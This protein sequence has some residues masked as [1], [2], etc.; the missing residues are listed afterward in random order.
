M[1]DLEDQSDN[2]EQSQQQQSQDKFT[3]SGLHKK[4]KLGLESSMRQVSSTQIAQAQNKKSSIMIQGSGVNLGP[5]DDRK[6]MKSEMFASRR[7]E[8][9]SIAYS[10]AHPK[11]NREER[12]LQK[13]MLDWENLGSVFIDGLDKELKNV[14]DRL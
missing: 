12:M 14:N 5:R 6:S 4:S 11:K 9:K 10:Q 8:N 1:S 3:G 7:L 13:C 2:L